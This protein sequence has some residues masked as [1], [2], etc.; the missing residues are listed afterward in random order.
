MGERPC[1]LQPRVGD[2]APLG[3]G[4]QRGQ[5][6]GGRRGVAGT[7]NEGGDS[8]RDDPVDQAGILSSWLSVSLERAA[9]TGEVGSAV[10]GADSG[11]SHHGK[12]TT[13]P[14]SR[15]IN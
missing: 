10:S 15:T 9:I 11:P 4:G 3:L 7:T 5:V 13:P 14:A 8:L 1:G 2:D 12:L 6:G